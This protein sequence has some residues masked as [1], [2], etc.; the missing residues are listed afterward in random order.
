MLSFGGNAQRTAYIAQ[1][2]Q[3]SFQS[4]S[5][6]RA[7]DAAR[8]TT[9][10]HTRAFRL[11]NCIVS[12]EQRSP[13]MNN[14]SSFRS[15]ESIFDVRPNRSLHTK[16]PS[17]PIRVYRRW[18]ATHCAGSS[19]PTQTHQHNQ[20]CTINYYSFSTP[21]PLSPKT[22]GTAPYS[23]RGFSSKIQNKPFSLRH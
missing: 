3:L 8:D 6:T 13:N 20:R 21:P 5:M 9:K 10:N 15:R 7:S 22:R 4:T 1:I 18:Q 16:C 19:S 23:W 17:K 12:I 14:P 11:H 2:T